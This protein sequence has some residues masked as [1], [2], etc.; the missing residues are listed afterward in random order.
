[1]APTE[2][3]ITAYIELVSQVK[4]N[5]QGIHLYGVARPS[6]QAEAS[7]LKQLPSQWFEALAV[8]IRKTGISVQ[9]SP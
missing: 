7:R 8:R 4:N 9:V 2:A 1:M 6:M 3:D 5:I